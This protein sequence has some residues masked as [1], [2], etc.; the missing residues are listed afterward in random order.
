VSIFDAYVNKIAE[1]VESVRV[2]GR[3]IRELDCPGDPGK[4]LEGLP[5]RVGPEAGSGVILR[6][7]TFVEL[8]SPDTSSCAF[9]LWTDNPALVRDGKVTL[10]G[11]D[12]QESEGTS[13]PFA[14]VLMLGGTELGTEEHSALEQNQYIAD[15]IE[16]YMLRSTP[17]RMWGRVSK[18][19]ATKGF[20]FGMLGKALMAIFKTAVP[21]VQAMEIVFITSDK[22]DVQQL[23]SIAEQVRM[24]SK[25]IVR[26]TWLVRGYDVLECTFGWDCNSCSYKPVCDEIRE[27][28]TV[29]K[30][31]TRRTT[32]SKNQ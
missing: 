16:G 30:K 24:I 19:V 29:R 11:P 18:D 20:D 9:M 32:T 23:N 26:E 6:G 22:E 13:L 25:D 28:I 1:Y 17:E 15:Q 27:V 10:I 7:D 3:H 31:K 2:K 12:I 8:G 14:Q 21:K 5:I 4:L